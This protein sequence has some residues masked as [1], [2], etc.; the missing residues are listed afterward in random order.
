MSSAN[1]FNLDQST[2]L[3]FGKKLMYICDAWKQRTPHKVHSDGHKKSIL[4]NSKSLFW[5]IYKV[6]SDGLITSILTDT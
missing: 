3:S 6:Y 4:P 1:V 5:R 2:I